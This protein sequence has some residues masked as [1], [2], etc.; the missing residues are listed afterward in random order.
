MY[1]DFAINSELYPEEVK[2]FRS[3]NHDNWSTTD[4]KRFNTIYNRRR[5]REGKMPG[6]SGGNSG[7][8][9]VNY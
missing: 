2:K 3:D 1:E 9:K 4:I 6:N 7:R 8:T 5:K